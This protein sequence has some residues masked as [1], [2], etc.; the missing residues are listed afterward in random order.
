MSLALAIVSI[1]VMIPLTAIIL[2]TLGVAV[3][4]GGVAPALIGLGIV[5]L[6]I[7]T[8]NIL[9]NYWLFGAKSTRV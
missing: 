7:L 8:I 3:T 5:G 1:G 2:G 4:G 6:V 9:Y